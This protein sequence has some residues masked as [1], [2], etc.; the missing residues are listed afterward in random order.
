MTAELRPGVWWLSLRGVN[1]YL[2][3]DG[4]DLTL[5]D[6]GMPWQ[7]GK[8]RHGLEVAG[9]SASDLDRVLVTHY[10]LDHVGGL[11]SLVESA[12]DVE[13]YCGARDADVLTGLRKPPLGNRKG[14]FHR[15]TGFL[16]PAVDAPVHSVEDGDQIGGFEAIHTPGHTVGHTVYV[17]EDREAAMLGDLVRASDGSLE[18]SPALLSVDTDAV[19]A[20]IKRVLDRAPDFQAA[21]VGHGDPLRSGGRAALADAR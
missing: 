11:R 7:A 4:D 21:C 19:D 14:L 20:S 13:V 18:P 12:G 15:L 6:A 9:F 8:I 5:V 1:A 17:H 3:E 10:D 2:V 16:V